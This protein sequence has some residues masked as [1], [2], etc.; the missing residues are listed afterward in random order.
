MRWSSDLAY[1]VGLITTDGSLS[2]DGRHI[3]LTSKDKEQIDT[4]A[5]ILHLNNKVEFKISSYNP[6]GLYYQIQFGNVKIYRFLLDIGLTPNKTKTLSS[7]LIPDKY[8]ADFLRGHLDGDGYTYSY[9]DKRW[10]SSFMLYTGFVSASKKHL[11]WINEKI[12]KLYGIE[13]R[14]GYSGKSVFQLKFA[15]NSSIK[16]L[17][18]IYYS[19]TIS[20][21]SRK[22]FKIQSAL[23]IISTCGCA[24]MVYRHA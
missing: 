24:E 17:K 23:A 6:N 18:N 3:N 19:P 15:K 2:I 13:G 5:K 16:L 20:C 12:K 9:W 4:F 7:L 14:I 22:R 21:L 11:E 8:F 10:K 1:V